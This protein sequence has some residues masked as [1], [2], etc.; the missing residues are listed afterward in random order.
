CRQR[1]STFGLEPAS[2]SCT[3]PSDAGGIPLSWARASPADR[4]PPDRPP[5]AVPLA[6]MIQVSEARFEEL[7][8]EALDSLPEFLGRA[9]EN[10][11]VVVEPTAAGGR[12]LFGLY[13]GVPLTRRS[14]TSY[15]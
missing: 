2:C 8:G 12:S 6:G 14:P 10:V 5:A 3:P 11:A 9:M 1:R 7:V 4:P 13:Q 15:S